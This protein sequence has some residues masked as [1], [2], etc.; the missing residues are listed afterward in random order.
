MGAIAVVVIGIASKDTFEVGFVEDQE[1]IEALRSDR[2]YEPL[3]KCVGIGSPVG[4]LEDLGALSLEDCIEARDILGVAIADQESGRY[5]RSG[6]STGDV[7]CLLGNPRCAPMSGYSGDPD[8]SAA[9]VDEEQHVE[10]LEEHGVD[11]E[12]VRGHDSGRLGAEELAP[13]RTTSTRSRAQAVVLHDARDGAGGQAHAE[14]AQLPLDAPLA[15]SRI[16]FRQAHNEGD[17]LLVDGRTTGRAVRVCPALGHESSMPAEQGLG[18]DVGESPLRP[19]QK[20]TQR[21]QERTIGGLEGGATHLAPE[22]RHFVSKSEDLD[23]FRSF[24]T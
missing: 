15:P 6:E 23:L 7:P 16:L 20:T 18:R 3:G 4:G 13:G 11:M 9:K 12:E 22:Y 24:R 1:M 10:A 14:L 21:G 8:P 5:L 17:R 19:R 2:S